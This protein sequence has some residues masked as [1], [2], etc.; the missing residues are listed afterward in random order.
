MDT[1]ITREDWLLRAVQMLRPI[2]ERAEYALPEVK[3]SI[4]FTSGGTN[5]R[6]LGQCWSSSSS[7]D[8]INQI[9]IAPGESDPVAILDTL[10]HEL[11]HAVDDCVNGHGEEFKKIALAVGLKGPMRSAGANEFLKQDLIQIALVLGHF[12]HGKLR[13][14]GPSVASSV[15]RPGQNVKSVVLKSLC[16]RGIY[17]SERLFALRIWSKWSQP[18][19]GMNKNLTNGFLLTKVKKRMVVSTFVECFLCL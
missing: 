18:A 11:V 5:A 12:P 1:Q 15:K 13:T 10:T 7:A 14:P 8:G 19:N 4:G 9:F 16:S 6:H 3:V 2:F 17:T